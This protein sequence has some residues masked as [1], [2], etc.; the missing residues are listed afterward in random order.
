MLKTWPSNWFFC[1]YYFYGRVS[2]TDATA[3][4][5]N[6]SYVLLLS[7]L[8]LHLMKVLHFSCHEKYLNLLH[9]LPLLMQLMRM[10]KNGASYSI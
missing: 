4:N 5:K 2:K 10:Q 6:F 1:I 3:A 7:L 9:N 8:L